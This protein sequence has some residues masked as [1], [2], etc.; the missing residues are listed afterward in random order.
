MHAMLWR[1]LDTPGHDACRLVELGEGWRVEG[2]AIFRHEGQP[3]Q[4]RYRVTADPTW[5]SEHGE[6]TGW[7]GD[8]PVNLSIV[9]QPDGEWTINGLPVPDV[10]GCIDLDL[11]FTP[12]TN[13]FAL[14]RLALEIGDGADAPAAWLD[15]D[16]W[17]LVPL[18]QRYER[19]TES[20]YWY[21]APSVGYAELIEV[22]DVGFVAQYTNLWTV[23]SL[24]AGGR[25]TV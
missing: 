17:R 9:R 15:I 21:E 7:I 13:L 4:L 16:T 8:A 22:T 20:S 10:R 1:R 24:A 11:A 5:R 2:T 19:R 18:P 23:E 14:R 12:A 6:V 25:A 3:A